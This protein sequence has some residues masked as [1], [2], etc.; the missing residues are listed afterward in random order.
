M[1]PAPAGYDLIHHLGAGGMGN[2][3]V[4]KEHAA[5]RVVAIKFLRPTG[6]AATGDRFLTEVRALGR[7]EHPSIVR[8][9]SVD[10]DRCDP[11]YSMEYAA[12]GTLA[13]RIKAEGPFDPAEAVRLCLQLADALA[14][15]HEAEIFHRDIKP[16][17]VIVMADGTPKLSDFGLAKL[18]DEHDELTRTTQAIGTPAFMPPE[19]ITRKLGDISPATDVYGLGATL[20]A[21]LTG[22]APFEGD[23]NEDIISKVKSETPPRPRAL[24]PDL[25][26]GLEAVVLKCLEKRPADRYACSDELAKDL[27][28][29]LEGKQQSAPAMTRWRRT[30]KWVGRHA[31]SLRAMLTV[32]VIAGMVA[33]FAVAKFFRSPAPASSPPDLAGS[34]RPVADSHEAIQSELQA[35]RKLTLVDVKG[36]PR[37]HD[38]GLTPSSLGESPANDGTATF[39]TNATTLLELVRSP[40]VE[41]YRITADLRHMSGDPP[42][43]NGLRSMSYIGLYCGHLSQPGANP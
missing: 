20:Y 17:N 2:V 31:V 15:V 4:A 9:I 36:P 16:S 29:C 6:N 30:R 22:K 13:D 40:G 23:S 34:V 19:Q 32:L 41:R 18:M 27:E 28:R 7:L 35:G 42:P 8:I 14:A 38:W 37:W 5:Q 11:F 21:M 3:W 1:R 33:G 39:Q 25:P 24:R 12:G 26:M 43:P 10:L